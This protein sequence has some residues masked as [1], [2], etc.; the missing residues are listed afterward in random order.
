[1]DGKTG[2]S[3]ALGRQI[4]VNGHDRLLSSSVGV[5]TMQSTT[6]AEV[7][8]SHEG[9]SDGGLSLSECYHLLQNRRRRTVIRYVAEH[10]ESVDI[11]TLS[12]HLV[13]QETDEP[14][15]SQERHR[16]YVALYQT[17]LPKLDEYGVVEY[18]K[19]RGVVRPTPLVSV[20]RTRMEA[21]T[22]TVDRRRRWAS[23]AAGTLV[24]F[25]AL[26]AVVS[27]GAGPPNVWLAGGV[28]LA[29]STVGQE[30]CRRTEVDA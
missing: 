3:A 25:A 6:E 16:V 7:F 12:E 22:S 10:G 1:M 29:A 24:A 20:L 15:S 27:L 17:H 13:R 26:A 23:I 19:D 2:V 4:G 28:G 11:G 30:L 21:D 9:E 14:I 5:G 18:D 8:D